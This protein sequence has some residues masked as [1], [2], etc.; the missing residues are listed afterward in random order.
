MATIFYDS[1]IAKNK[2]F[3][4]GIIRKMNP[5]T[6]WSN[7][8]YNHFVLT[9]IS[10]TSENFNERAQARKEMEIAERKMKFWERHPDFDID[11]AHYYRKKYF[12]L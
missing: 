10:N 6:Q 4:F 5:N 12:K 11:A 2:D 9:H 7:H 3:N 8:S 1:G